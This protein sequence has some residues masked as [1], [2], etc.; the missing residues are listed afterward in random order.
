MAVETGGQLPPLQ[1]TREDDPRVL[2]EAATEDYSLHV[3]PRTW[4]MDRGKLTMAWWAVATAFFYMYFAA[5]IA[6]AYGTVN[7]LIGIVLTVVAY[8][9]VNT[10]ITRVAATSGLTVALFS[11]SMFGFV[12]AAIATLIFAATAIYYLVFEGSVIAVAA[13]TF[14][15]ARS[16]SGTRS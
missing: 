14:W 4:R 7:A 5:F 2:E 8:S 10:V 12:G 3:V 6:L 15:A 16:T 11:R 9:L 1:V 13:Q